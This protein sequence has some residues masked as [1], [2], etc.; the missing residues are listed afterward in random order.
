[1]QDFSYLN[2]IVFIVKELDS[3]VGKYFINNFVKLLTESK[4][5]N[6]PVVTLNFKKRFK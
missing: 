3:E 1:M 4:F 6:Y 2:T 5:E